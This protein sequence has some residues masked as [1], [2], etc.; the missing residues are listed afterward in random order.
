MSIA[1]HEATPRNGSGVSDARVRY[2]DHGIV[3]S[4]EYSV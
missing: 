3:L 2:P 4:T 1:P